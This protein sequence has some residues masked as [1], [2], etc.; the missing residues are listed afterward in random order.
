M[1]EVG[2]GGGCP[3]TGVDPDEQETALAVYQ[4]GDRDAAISLELFLGESQDYFFWL[5]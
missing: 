2:L 3:Q 5:S 1:T 4:V